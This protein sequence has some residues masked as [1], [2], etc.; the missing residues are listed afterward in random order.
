MG[1]FSTAA[2]NTMLDALT[3]DRIQLHSG[4]PGS[5]GT[6]NVVSGTMAAVTFSAASSGSR[7]LSADKQ[8]TGLTPNQVVTYVSFWNYNGGSPIFHGSSAVT[9][10]QAANSAGEYTVKG[11]T[12]K[13]Q[14]TDS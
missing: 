11:T 7:P 2:K 3:V 4:D 12:T 13:I 5:E 6:A 10:D 1:A 14:I 8:Y 9:G